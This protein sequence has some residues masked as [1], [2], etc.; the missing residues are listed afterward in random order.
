MHNIAASRK[1]KNK[2]EQFIFFFFLFFEVCREGKIRE[3]KY[4]N[5][6]PPR[7]I[8][9]TL[10]WSDQITWVA[11]AEEDPNRYIG[12]FS[13]SEAHKT[14]LYNPGI[15]ITE[16]IY[17]RVVHIDGGALAEHRIRIRASRCTS[18]REKQGYLS[19]LAAVWSAAQP[20]CPPRLPHPPAEPLA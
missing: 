11:L 3:K 12:D 8:C 16:S 20:F 19:A 6:I 7:D 5:C 1:V 18:V 2:R 15:Y 9:I 17:I 13:H 4:K 14:E 10:G